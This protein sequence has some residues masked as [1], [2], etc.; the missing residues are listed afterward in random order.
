MGYAARVDTGPGQLDHR[1]APA[2]RVRWLLGTFRG[3]SKKHMPRYLDEFIYRFHRRW[4]EGD[5]FGFVLNRALR[6][7]PFPYSRLTAELFG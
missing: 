1:Q 5:L 3:V 7:E 2:G 6:G 4:R